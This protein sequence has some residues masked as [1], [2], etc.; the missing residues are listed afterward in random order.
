M[1]KDVTGCTI[2]KFGVIWDCAMLCCDVVNFLDNKISFALHIDV[3][4]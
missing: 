2:G 4:W 3:I 1:L